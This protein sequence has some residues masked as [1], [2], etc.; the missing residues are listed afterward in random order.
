MHKTVKEQLGQH[1]TSRLLWELSTLYSRGYI[2]AMY[3]Y[4]DDL[5]Y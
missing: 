4:L 1:I 3:M 5:F 2:G